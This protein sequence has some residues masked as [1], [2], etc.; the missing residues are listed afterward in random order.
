VPFATTWGMK[1]QVGSVKGRGDSRCIKVPSTGGTLPAYSFGF[2]DFNGPI[3]SKDKGV[4]TSDIFTITSLL[5][6]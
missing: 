6:N 3:S 2:I 5:S 1:R 4:L